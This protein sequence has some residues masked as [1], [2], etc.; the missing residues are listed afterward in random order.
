MTRPVRAATYGAVLRLPGAPRAFAAA[1]LGRLSYATLSLSLLVTV[2]QST[3]SYA[4]AGT[5]LAVF[6]LASVVMPGK[7]RLVDR[8]GQRRVLPVL[9]VGFACALLAVVGLAASGT[10]AARTY[11]VLAAASG[12]AAPPLG[13]SMRALW[14][15]L[16]PDP[17]LRRRAYSLDGVVEEVLHAVGPLLVGIVLTVSSGATALAV[18]AVLNVAGST[19]LA[20]SSRSRAA[21]RRPPGW[22]PRPTPGWRSVLPAPVSSATA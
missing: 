11:V 2:E 22:P 6:A 7:S 16:T 8:Y 14:A 10:P 4:G 17:V 18:T 15:A 12:L 20:T 19:A 9:S 1:T 3:G 13:P 21:P 5:T